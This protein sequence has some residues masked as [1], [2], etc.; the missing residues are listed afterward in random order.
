MSASALSYIHQIQAGFDVGG[1]FA[2]EEID[3]DAAC[4]RRLYILL[5][6]WGGWINHNDVHATATGIERELLRHKF[7]ALVVADHVGQRDRRIFV[8]RVNIFCKAHGGNAGSMNDALDTV[9]GGRFKDS[10]GAVDVGAIH[11]VRIAN[12]EAVIGGD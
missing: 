2:F 10:A 6:D 8:G 9:F 12:P 7:G 11:F 3:N 5:A 4:W 1:K